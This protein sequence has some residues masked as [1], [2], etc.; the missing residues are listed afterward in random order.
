MEKHKCIQKDCLSIQ[1]ANQL[2]GAN[3]KE[4]LFDWSHWRINLISK[5]K[6][7]IYRVYNHYSSMRHK[8]YTYTLL[9]HVPSVR[10][11]LNVVISSHSVT[12][13]WHFYYIQF[14]SFQTP[15]D[16]ITI[17]LF[18]FNFSFIDHDFSEGEDLRIIYFI[19]IALISI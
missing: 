16:L 12:K 17:F 19:L 11:I 4:P 8:E 1:S 5:L 10:Q 2:I 9:S 13:Y 15:F 18:F 3:S 6:Y 14:L 7:W